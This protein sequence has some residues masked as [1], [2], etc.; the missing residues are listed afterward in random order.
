MNKE[1]GEVVLGTLVGAAIGGVVGLV[2]GKAGQSD[3]VAMHWVS[4]SG[5]TWS[6]IGFPSEKKFYLLSGN[7]V[8]QFCKLAI[9]KA[10]ATFAEIG[11]TATPRV[12]PDY[13]FGGL[14]TD[15]GSLTPPR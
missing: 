12:P 4:K 5:V 14:I 7:Y 2:A 9:P 1:K 3:A 13:I 6:A 15:S 10:M 8:W 11:K